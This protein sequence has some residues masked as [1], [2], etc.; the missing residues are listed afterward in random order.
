MDFQTFKIGIIA[1]T[2]LDKDA[3]HIYV[4]VS[5]Y[6]LGLILLRPIIKRQGS[7]AFIALI[8]VSTVALLGEYLDNRETIMAVGMF[9]LS[10]AAIAASIH[11]LMNTCALP[12]LLYGLMRW[13]TI[14]YSSNHKTHL[15]KR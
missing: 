10:S 13:T 12:Y 4:G 1:A 5:V 11:D 9:E 3:L 14:F 7:R 15:L 6:L 8:M 2:G